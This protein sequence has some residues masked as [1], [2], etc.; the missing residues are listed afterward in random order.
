M[1]HPQRIKRRHIYVAGFFPTGHVC[2][3]VQKQSVT[4]AIALWV[5]LVISSFQHT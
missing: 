2:T 3:G 5:P 1:A 4:D